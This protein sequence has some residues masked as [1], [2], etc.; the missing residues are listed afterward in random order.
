MSTLSSTWQFLNSGFHSGDFNMQFDEE[1]ANKLHQGKISPTLRLYG[2]N[3]WAISLGYNQKE[4]DIN[5]EQ[6]KHDGID[7]VRRATGGRAILHANELTYGVVMFAQGKSVND[8]YCEIRKALVCGLKKICNDVSY[9][10]SQPHFPTLYKK[11]E[12]VPCFASSARYEVQID[13]KKLVGSAQRRFFSH[14]DTEIV[15]QHGSI[16]LGEEHKK[17]VNYL[18]I[19]NDEVKEKIVSD[20]EAKT[21]E[22]STAMQRVVSFDEVAEVVRLG[23]EETFGFVFPQQN[24]V[25]I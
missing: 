5:I 8:V 13:G 17:L 7:I 20:F 25:T 6:C 11:A 9:E 18:A 14:T 10:V 1:L 22:L 24:E 3:P 21:I 16:L 12:S 2:W 15:L 4:S 19:S 23:F